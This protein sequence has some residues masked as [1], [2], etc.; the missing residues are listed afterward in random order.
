MRLYQNIVFF[1]FTA[2]SLNR[3][4]CSVTVETQNL[5]SLR[6]L[7]WIERDMFVF[8]YCYFVSPVAVETQLCVSTRILYFLLSQGIKFLKSGSFS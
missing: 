1:A 4:T 8:V 7:G 3:F 6:T 2:S 5:A